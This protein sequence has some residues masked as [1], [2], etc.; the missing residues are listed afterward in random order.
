[1]GFQK[2]LKMRGREYNMFKNILDKIATKRLAKEANQ[3]IFRMK[4][5]VVRKKLQGYYETITIKTIDIPAHIRAENHLNKIIAHN[6]LEK[7][8]RVADNREMAQ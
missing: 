7:A 3:A 2:T 4:C 6:L 5:N 8:Y 1:M